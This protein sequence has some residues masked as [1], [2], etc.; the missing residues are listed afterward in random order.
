[1]TPFLS[2]KNLRFLADMVNYSDVIEVV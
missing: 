2:R 1:M